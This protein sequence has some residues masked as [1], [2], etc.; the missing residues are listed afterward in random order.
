MYP[1][2][3]VGALIF[4]NRGEILLISGP[5]F[6]NHYVIPGGHIEY[7]ETFEGALV[8]EVFEE[9]GLDIFDIEILSLQ[10][11]IAPEAY[12]QKKHFIFIDFICRTKDNTIFLNHEA[13]TYLWVL[14]ENALSL[15]LEKYTKDL[16]SSWL[17]KSIEKSTIIYKP[18]I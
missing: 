2:V 7:G 12:H 11:V 14:P 15:R 8:R 9:T 5:K 17:N 6:K 4:N 3:T 10:E 18:K 16:M 1:E 13:E